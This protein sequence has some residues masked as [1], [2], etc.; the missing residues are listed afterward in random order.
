MDKFDKTDP[1]NRQERI[2]QEITDALVPAV[3]HAVMICLREYDLFRSPRQNEP[4]DRMLN[5]REA[6]E[7]LQ[8]TP[9]AIRAWVR[10]KELIPRR[11]GSDMR[12]LRSELLEWTEEQETKRAKKSAR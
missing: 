12:F 11:V 9:E 6:A 1:V 5:I 7:F 4:D 2:I 10:K 3:R 8:V